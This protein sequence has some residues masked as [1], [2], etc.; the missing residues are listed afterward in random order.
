MGEGSIKAILFIDLH[1]RGQHKDYSIYRF[2]WE[3]AA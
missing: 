2:T 3:G 1:V